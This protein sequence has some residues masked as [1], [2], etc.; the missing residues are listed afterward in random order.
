MGVA[1]YFWTHLDKKKATTC[2]WRLDHIF[3]TKK[4]VEAAR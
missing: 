1:I 4:C 2:L 3:E